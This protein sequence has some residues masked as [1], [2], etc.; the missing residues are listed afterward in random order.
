MEHDILDRNLWLSI[1]NNIF[2]VGIPK[3]CEWNNIDAII[4]V[5][6]IIGS[7]NNSNHMFYPDGGGLDIKSSKLSYEK[8]CIEIH[9]GL[10]DILK[11]KCLIF[12]SFPDPIWNYFR[13]ETNELNPSGVY[14][15]SNYPSE[16]LT[17]LEPM[18]Y[19][20]RSHW[21]IN[22][23]QGEDLPE[24]AR[25]LTRHLKGSFVI[26]AKASYYN[27]ESSTYDGRHNKM[28]AVEFRTYIEKATKSGW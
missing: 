21:D 22:E 19:V 4:N 1:L 24:T 8:D 20:H 14:K 15:E 7:V 2:P 9:T 11:P 17:E 12:E 23:Y 13:I 27:L 26:F 28:S 16:E 6:N 3:H 10:I 25:V 5:L 18:R